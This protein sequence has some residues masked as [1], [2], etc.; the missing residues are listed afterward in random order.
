MPW[1]TAEF[2]ESCHDGLIFMLLTKLFTGL[3][4]LSTGRK[5]S[6]MDNSRLEGPFI[7]MLGPDRIVYPR[8]AV[9]AY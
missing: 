5:E 8:I 7:H 3:C 6:V 9:G 4:T 2:V 1:I